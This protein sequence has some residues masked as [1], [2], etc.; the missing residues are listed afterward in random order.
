VA[1]LAFGVFLFGLAMGWLCLRHSKGVFSAL[2]FVVGGTV[3]AWFTYASDRDLR[4]QT[5]FE[6]MAPGSQGVRVGA[7]APVRI[8]EFGVEHPATEHKLMV[9]P[10]TPKSPIGDVE[11]HFQLI[12]P[13]GTVLL[14]DQNTYRVRGGTRNSRSQWEPRYF[15][16]TPTQGGKHRLKLTILTTE[17][18]Q[19]HVRVGDPLKTDGKRIPGY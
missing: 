7:D 12:D 14:S 10:H 15:S 5:L 19:I 1:L 6:V 9:A 11:L 8:L 16:F 2:A 13:A 4:V 18:P 3:A 17:V